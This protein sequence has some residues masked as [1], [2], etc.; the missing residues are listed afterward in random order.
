MY[1]RIG[2]IFVKQED[3]VEKGDIIAEISN[4][5]LSSEGVFHFEI[6]KSKTALDP[7]EWIE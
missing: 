1:A 3:K 2:S 6:R 5:P 4:S 7:E